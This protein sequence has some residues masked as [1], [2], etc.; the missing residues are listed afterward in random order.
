MDN[1]K[2][3]H[4]AKMLPIAEYAHN[5]WKSDT[6]RK[7]PYQLLIDISLQV[8]IKLIDDHTPMAVDCLKA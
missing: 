1:T 2:A 6:T 4:W 7:S 3:E 8:D 5:S